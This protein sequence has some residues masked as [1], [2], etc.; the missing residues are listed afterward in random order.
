MA[1]AFC[2]IFGKG[3]FVAESAGLEPGTLNPYVVRAMAERGVDISK[4]QTKSVFNFFTQGRFYNA[5]VT[6]CSKDTAERCPIFPGAL[7]TLHWPFDDPARFRGSDEE[8]M[9]QVRLVRDA[10]EK[11][12]KEFVDAWPEVQ[13]ALTQDSPTQSA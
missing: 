3:T 2:N 11:K 5:V 7:V 9:A 12:V 6:V 13:T 4:N 8:I 1:E 10:I